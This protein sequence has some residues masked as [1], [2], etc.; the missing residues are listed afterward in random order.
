MGIRK[1]FIQ[2]AAVLLALPATASFAAVRVE[3]QG[4]RSYMD[5][6]GTNAA[7][8]EAVF[9]EHRI[10]GSDFTWSPDVSVGWID[11][12]D[13]SRYRYSRYSTR[14]NI[15]LVAAGARFRFA[16]RNAWYRPL[17]FSF[18]PVWHD[19]RTQALSSWYEFAS[20]LGWQGRHWSFA[21]R[22][23]SNGSMHE[24]NRGETMAVVGLALGG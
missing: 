24:P 10:G 18:Q 16:D 6:H 17:F 7:F 20:T 1:P 9:D 23:I 21:I 11:G 12:R 22:H 19:G 5:S 3:V 15:R 14:D 8:V 13:V 2:L 4:G